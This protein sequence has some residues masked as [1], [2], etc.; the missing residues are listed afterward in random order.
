MMLEATLQYSIPTV[1]TSDDSSL[2]VVLDIYL[3]RYLI[4]WQSSHYFFEMAAKTRF[5]DDSPWA[6][7]CTCEAVDRVVC[8]T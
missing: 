5:S 2:S 1:L 4:V 6:E 8:W 3:L 7:S